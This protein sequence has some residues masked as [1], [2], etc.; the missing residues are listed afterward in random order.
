[1]LDETGR[2]GQTQDD[3]LHLGWH[4]VSTA[5]CRSVLHGLTFDRRITRRSSAALRSTAACRCSTSRRR[6]SSRTT[7]TRATRRRSSCRGPSAGTRSSARPGSRGSIRR[8]LWRCGPPPGAWS[9]GA[10]QPYTRCCRTPTTRR[11]KPCTSPTAR[12]G[13]DSPSLAP[14]VNLWLQQS[15]SGCRSPPMAAAVHLWLQQSTSGCS[16]PPLAA[17][18][19]LWLQQSVTLRVSKHF[20]AYSSYIRTQGL[21]AASPKKH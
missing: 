3:E 21:V 1:M 6:G 19:H 17:T 5:P 18:V 7:P 2:T 14:A 16:S 4:F 20:G 13:C 8:R 9:S 12:A 11:A 15:T 10:R